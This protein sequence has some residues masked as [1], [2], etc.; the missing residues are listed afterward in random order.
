MKDPVHEQLSRLIAD[1]V[2]DV[3]PHERLGEIRARVAPQTDRR[4]W[5]A[6][7]GVTLAAA[8]AVT[9][10]ALIG[11]HGLTNAD[12]PVA[13]QS[14]DPTLHIPGL[15]ARAVYYIGDTP[16]G[17]RLFREFHQTQNDFAADL[18]TSPSLDPDYRTPWLL[19]AFK[20]ETTNSETGFASVTLRDA[21][22]HDRP[23]SMSAQEAELA[24]QQVIYTIQAQA[25][26]PVAVQFKLNGNP[27]D[28]VF[29]VPTSEPLAAAP[30]LDVLALVSISNPSEGEDVTGSFVADGRASSFEGTVPWELRDGAGAVVKQG[31]AQAGMDDH[32]IPWKTEP[33]DVS[34]LSPGEY[35]FVAMT[36]DASGGEGPGPFTDTRTVVVR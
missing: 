5:Y 25:Q 28:Q 36:D 24:I 19:G 32:L 12:G 30:Q 22:A 14:Q 8:A 26:R 33:I 11:N 35:T 20:A 10:I 3:E 16:H 6:A 21:S 9:A 2:A 13:T 23:L 27:I 15:K 34:D 7:G 31:F 17:P 1:A 4:G 29:G 18:V